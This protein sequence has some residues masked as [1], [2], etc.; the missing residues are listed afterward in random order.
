MAGQA[1]PRGLPSRR[2][3]NRLLREQR[4]ARRWKQDDVA[5]GIEDLAQQLGEQMPRITAGLV[6]KWERRVRRPGRYYGPRLCLLFDL[7]PQDLGLV[8]SPRLL[9]DWRRLSAALVPARSLDAL[10]HRFDAALDSAARGN[11]LP[12]AGA[13]SVGRADLEAVRD[14][15]SIFSRVDQR[16]GGGH[17]RTAVVQYLT[18]DV[19][20]YLRGHFAD[21]QVRR[22]M[23]SAASELAYLSGWMAFDNAEH[24]LAQQYFAEAV[25]LAL[26]ADDPP[27]AGHVLRAMAHQAVDLGNAQQ[28]LD[29]A[30]ASMDGQRY[31][32]ASPRERAL[33]GVVYARSLAATRQKHAAATAL[34]LAEN[35]LAAAEPG[36]E[37][38]DRVFFFGE[39]SLAHE[40]ACALRD[41]GD[42]PGAVQ[43]FSRSVRTRDAARF[44]RTHAVTLGYLGAV[45]ATQGAIEE[46][47]AT[48]SK[49]LDAMHGINSGRTRQVAIDISSALAPY[50]GR[51]IQ[52]VADLDARAAA[53][54]AGVG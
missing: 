34:I 3:P 6:D 1:D 32:L 8:A 25:T 45:Q 27:M 35:D 49:A 23:F 15:V 33:L 50:S 20:R 18:S 40:A 9:A 30:T 54:L 19:A 2:E 12:T 17:A 44:T 29:L 21:D 42:L 51:G 37:E 48:W 52:V 53:Y 43:E 24:A 47:S 14:M 16:R 11:I 7:S 46:A 26:E 39:A 28:A 5:A 10:R 22:A 13:R 38:P 31:A 36:N 4:R 41:T